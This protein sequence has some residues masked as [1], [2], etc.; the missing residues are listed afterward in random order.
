M[1]F[2]F[3]TFILVAFILVAFMLLTFIFGGCLVLQDVRILGRSVDFGIPKLFLEAPWGM[4]V[5]AFGRATDL[6]L[7]EDVADC[8][9]LV[10]LVVK[11]RV[12][13]EFD[14]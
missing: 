10:V 5:F 12:A 14:R 13:V 6:Q 2:I 8:P 1:T 4:L 7:L 9:R 11:L 3:M